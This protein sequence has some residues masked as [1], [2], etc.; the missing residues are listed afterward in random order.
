MNTS[1]IVLLCLI[2]IILWFVYDTYFQGNFEW[3]KSSVD[4][5][6]YKVQSLPD[7]EEAANLLAQIRENIV[8]L[9]G[10]LQKAY[11]DDPRTE[12][13]VVN[14]NPANISEGSNG[15]HTEYTSYSVNKGE[16]IVFCLRAKNDND[17]LVD[18]NTMMFVALHELAHVAT[19]STGHTDEFWSNFTWLLEESINIGVYKQHDY[20]AK[21]VKYCGIDITDSPLVD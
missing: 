17:Q 3:V 20:R 4:N 13:I 7:K 11:Q 10:H 21:P 15:T 5:N 19:E 16:K 14:F 18:I 12:R 6:V 1:F 9:T 8:T 2:G